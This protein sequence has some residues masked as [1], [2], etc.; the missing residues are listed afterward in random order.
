MK[1]LGLIAFFV[2]TFTGVSFASTWSRQRF[3]SSISNAEPF[4]KYSPEMERKRGEAERLIAKNKEKLQQNPD[5]VQA[6][7]AIGNSY[8]FLEEYEAA[9]NSFKEVLRVTPNDAEAYWGMG[10]AYTRTGN[11]AKA[12]N[13]YKEAVR[14]DPRF[15]KAQA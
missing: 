3:A 14:V 13:F 12:L 8:L 10:Q 5:D 11:N 6:H 1:K 4:Q 15:A 9:Y 2:V 7:K